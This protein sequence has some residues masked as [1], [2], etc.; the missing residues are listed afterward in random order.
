MS[1]AENIRQTE[2]LGVD[3]I[4]FIFYPHSSRYITAMPGYLPERAARV[5]VFVNGKAEEVEACAARF[6][7]DYVQL[8]G[9]EPPEYCKALAGKGLRIIKAFSIAQVADLELTNLYKGLCKYFLFDT[10]CDNHGGSGRQFDWRVLQHYKGDTP[11]L[12]S[13]GI[14]P[15][16]AGALKCFAHPQYAGIDINSLFETSPGRKD[17]ERINEF[18]KQLI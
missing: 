3:M 15:A 5:G 1:E 17:T 9:D 2:G 13:G 10:K 4:G 8:H 6:G 11:F 12:L 7:L 18:M 16:D 14:G